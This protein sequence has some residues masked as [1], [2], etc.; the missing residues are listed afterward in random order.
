MSVSPARRLAIRRQH[1]AALPPDPPA[2]A[3]TRE[4]LTSA[5]QD[6][7]GYP[8]PSWDARA[9]AQRGRVKRAD[10]ARKPMYTMGLN[11]AYIQVQICGQEISTRFSSLVF[12]TGIFFLSP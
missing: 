5:R 12:K 3:E 2:A 7:R 9:P 10:G 1:R 6:G 4:D 11:P 8:F